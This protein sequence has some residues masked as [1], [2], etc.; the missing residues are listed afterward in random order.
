[1]NKD[2]RN[3][4]NETVIFYTN[5]CGIVNKIHELQVAAEMYNA[6]IL[7]VTETH[8]NSDIVNAEV[9]L[10][11][12]NI[13]RKDRN[14][15]KKCGG[16]CIYVH[17][18]ISAN[19][20]E[21]FDAPDS[22]AI[23]VNLNTISLLLICVYRSQNLDDAAQEKLLSQI[24][25]VKSHTNREIKLIGDLNLPNANWDSMAVNCNQNSCNKLFNI[26]R[27][28]LNAFTTMGLTPCLLNGTVTRRRVVED[29][30]Q[31]SHLDQFLTT[32]PE[33]VLNVETVA[34]LGKSDHLGIIANLKITNNS[35]FIKST[36][37]NWS[38][39]SVDDIIK[40]GQD[41]DWKYESEELDSDQMWEELSKK[42]YSVSKKC[43]K[44]TIKCTKSGV[45]VEKKPWDCTA[46]KR[47][48]KEKDQAW[49]KFETFPTSTHLNLALHKQGV[50]ESKELEQ[51]KEHE[52]KIAGNIKT[53]PKVF[54]KYLQSKRKIK[55]TVSAIKDKFNMLTRDPKKTA[56]LLAEFFSSTFVNEP[57]V[58]LEENCYKFCNE[59]I[60]DLEI[61]N[62]M[63]KKELKKLV[64]AKSMGP[65][66]IPPK[67]LS[68]LSENDGFVE[69]VTCLFNKCFSTESMPKIWKT[70]H[71]TALHKKD[72]KLIEATTDPSV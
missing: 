38:K 59:L 14:T 31:E 56:N 24:S 42:I 72:Q 47:R 34:P 10:K 5:A 36:K 17:N 26:Q 66:N 1:M 7:C 33:M 70:A 54:Y 53:N 16:S 25:S 64:I 51:M 67:V 49:N 6:K 28:Y 9:N 43:P 44:V 45:V 21:S 40:L 68:A 20:L 52:R 2:N 57:F 39:F 19:L 62:D 13:F 58:P 27:N 11:G 48:R 37:E 4:S 32:S 61:T 63:V 71:V 41:I 60:G 12:Y 29:T 18:T 55:E 50:Y 69:A 23:E 65:D 8:L 46:L 15:G 35:D 30:L 22:V 3:P